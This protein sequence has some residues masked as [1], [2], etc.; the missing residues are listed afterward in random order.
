MYLLEASWVQQLSVA[1]NIYIYPRPGAN[2]PPR[3]PFLRGAAT[4]GRHVKIEARKYIF[5]IGV[6]TG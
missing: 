6:R 3:K 5:F 2:R 1:L 4:D